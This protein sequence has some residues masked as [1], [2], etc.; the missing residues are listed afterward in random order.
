MTLG[1]PGSFYFA[2]VNEDQTLFDP[3]AFARVDEHIIDL[4]IKQE[5][6][7]HAE[8]NITIKNP[9][10]GLLNPGRKLWAWLARI[11]IVGGAPVPLFFGVVQGIPSD[12]F[13]ETITLKLVARPS[14]YIEDK[15]KV[16]ETLRVAPFYDPIFLDEKKRDDPDAILEGYSALYHVDR[17][18]LA[19]TV[20]DM[21]QGEDGVAVF[22]EDQ[23]FY[24]SLKF[25]VGESPLGTVRVEAGVQWKQR[26][27]GFVDGPSV[28][29]Q[30][31]TGDT[32]MNDWPKPGA[33]LGGGWKVEHSFVTDVYKTQLTPQASYGATVKVIDPEMEDCSINQST[34]H[35]S[36]PALLN[37][38]ATGAVSGAFSPIADAG[39]NIWYLLT[40]LDEIGL[41]DPP[42]TVKNPSSHANGIVV[43][44]WTLNCNWNLKY[45]ASRD[46]VETITM[47]VT[48]GT[49][50]VLASPTL[51]QRTETMKLGQVNVGE[52]LVEILAWSDFAGQPVP[53]GTFIYPN[54]PTQPGG[55][56]YQVA[57][58]IQGVTGAAAPHFNTA[59]NGITHDGTA[60][61]M[62]LGV[63][64][65]PLGPEIHFPGPYWP[66][67]T[68][69]PGTYYNDPITGTTQVVIQVDG[70]AGTEEPNFSDIPGTIT[71]DGT[72]PWASLGQSP[73]TTQPDWSEAT[74][75]AAGEIIGYAQ[76]QFDQNTGTMEETGFFVFLLALNDGVTNGQQV[77]ID[78]IPPITESDEVQPA[79]R[80]LFIV[81]GPIDTVGPYT[82]VAPPDESMPVPPGNDDFRDV[83]FG[84]DNSAAI[85][86]F[87]PPPNVAAGDLVVEQ[88]DGTV[89]WMSLGT[90]PPTLPI[91][92]GG[93]PINVTA[94]CFFP[95]ARGQQAVQY[96]I[97]KARARLRH[98]A[99]AVTITF[100]VPFDAATNITCRMNAQVTD[101]R[102]PGGIAEGKVKSYTMSAK[103]GH[104][105]VT[106]EIGVSCGL[107]GHVASSDGLPTYV[108]EGYVTAGYQQ[109]DGTQNMLATGDITYTPPNFVPFDDGLNFPLATLPTVGFGLSHNASWQRPY[110][111]EGLLTA[112][113]EA[114]LPSI[115]NARTGGLFMNS[116]ALNAWTI[117]L[118]NFQLTG[119]SLSYLMESHPVSWSCEIRPV[120][121]QTFSGG[122][123]VTVSQLEIPMGIDLSAPSEV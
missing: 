56:S 34:V 79:P 69:F 77:E 31:Y 51:T 48:A 85:P 103:D 24:D 45:E 55:T 2:W 121:G 41:C 28:S 58:P 64:V 123:N 92:V 98:R 14:T 25:Q 61:W 68:V 57:L 94:R 93:T 66:N 111:I 108:N 87:T 1:A 59:T 46:F 119:R 109:Y 81:P 78:Y 7:Q 105:S 52:P 37:S 67:F 21:L 73:L 114:N 53:A 117:A 91:P 10:V 101:P 12:L 27:F 88:G 42:K 30:S 17:V 47:D 75:I 118:N 84:T 29:V 74:P 9:R 4:E 38:G 49:Q 83:S 70:V 76:K 89:R 62:N 96:L 50:L 106:I 44:L 116:G 33:A 112:R 32:F 54:D 3:V 16:A 71:V 11:P 26:C 13:A 115:L 15:Q 60:Q 122:Y 8:L 36:Y 65:N 23:V 72:V 80:Q 113:E 100:E 102:L 6:G 43:P 86:T 18:S 63:G 40:W 104:E 39:G 5:E 22:T 90:F 110:I 97:A 99:R 95:T 19:T 107:N 120:Q 82:G 35:G 20:S